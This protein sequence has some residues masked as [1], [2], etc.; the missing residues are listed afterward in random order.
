MATTTIDIASPRTDDGETA[1][2]DVAPVKERTDLAGLFHLI[3]LGMSRVVLWFVATLIFFAVALVPFKAYDGSIVATG[4][5][6]PRIGPGDVVVTRQIDED[7]ELLGRVVTAEDPSQDRLLTH[8]IISDNG[9]GTYVT[10]GDDNSSPDTEPMP[11]DNIIGRG[12]ILVPWVGTPVDLAADGR[13]VML[14]TI[15]VGMGVMAYS[16]VD[17]YH[18]ADDG[19]GRPRNRVERSKLTVKVDRRDAAVRLT[20]AMLAV[21]AIAAPALNERSSAAMIAASR[22]NAQ[23]NWATVAELGVDNGAALFNSAT[24]VYAGKAYESRVAKVQLSGALGGRPVD[25]G[26]RAD[27][28]VQTGGDTFEDDLLVRV[29]YA[30]NPSMTGAVTKVDGKRLSQLSTGSIWLPSESDRAGYFRLTVWHPNVEQGPQAGAKVTADFT[31]FD[32]NNPRTVVASSTANSFTARQTYPDRVK[33]VDKP[34]VYYRALNDSGTSGTAA[35]NSRGT[36]TP[37]VGASTY[38]VASSPTST[39][40]A[41]SQGLSTNVDK[42]FTFANGSQIRTANQRTQLPANATVEAWVYY[43]D[44]KY[45]TIMGY[46]NSGLKTYEWGDHRLYIGSDKKP[47]FGGISNGTLALYYTYHDTTADGP[48]LTPGQWYLLQGTITPS[49]TRLYV[50]PAATGVTTE[51]AGAEDTPQSPTDGRYSG[52]WQAGDNYAGTGIGVSFDGLPANAGAYNGKVDEIAVWEST[53][54]TDQ[55]RT[56]YNLGAAVYDAAAG[57]GGSGLGR[58]ALAAG[59][60]AAV[61]DTTVPVAEAPAEVTAP[62]APAA[63]TPATEVTAPEAPAAGVTI[64]EAPAEPVAPEVPAAADPKPEVTPQPVTEDEQTL[65][66]LVAEADAQHA[67]EPEDVDLLREALIADRK[68]AEAAGHVLPAGTPGE[69]VAAWLALFAPGVLAEDGITVTGPDP[70]D[71]ISVLV[72][73]FAANGLLPEPELGLESEPLPAA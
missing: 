60:D 70:L 40:G 64:P 37:D 29:D 28:I 11:R 9:D 52:T 18:V 66:D 56:H 13:W 8:R 14:G 22:P 58:S 46:E 32:R 1:V 34:I 17:R 39:N 48:V 63:E 10:R 30:N 68:A 6:R 19:I 21:A 16:A 72:W 23:N 73:D 65:L 7:T 51:Y 38:A 47:H 27:N 53:L 26:L 20:A 43:E 24:P 5:M 59:S 31:W 15:V 33:L 49:A 4:S 35:T 3:R 36:T 50:T 44:G 57:S 54:S 71:P 61:T 62:E 45:G 41:L 69:A 25:V 55:M 67:L 2:A 42:H 12:F